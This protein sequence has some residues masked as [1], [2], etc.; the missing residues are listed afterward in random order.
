MEWDCARGYVHIALQDLLLFLMITWLPPCTNRLYSPLVAH[1]VVVPQ[2]ISGQGVNEVSLELGRVPLGGG[3]TL[4]LYRRL[5]DN[6]EGRNVN[7]W[8]KL[9]F[10]HLH[11]SRSSLFNCTTAF[12]GTLHS[13]NSLSSQAGLDFWLENPNIY[14]PS[15]PFA[16]RSLFA[17]GTAIITFNQHR[18]QHNIHQTSKWKISR[19][20]IKS[21][22]PRTRGSS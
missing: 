1:A 12:N 5:I 21:P 18:S 2:L 20:H 16:R 22:F 19:Q 8:A 13:L 6:D 9:S 4:F 3:E 7:I 17:H 14:I 11:R 10:N 15:F